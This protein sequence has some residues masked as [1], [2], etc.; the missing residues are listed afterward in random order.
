MGTGIS[1]IRRLIS[2][3]GLKA[4]E[5]EFG[6]FFMI[7]FPRPVVISSMAE[8]R[9]LKSSEKN[10]EEAREEVREKNLRLIRENPEITASELAEKSGLASKGIEWNI[11]KMK[12][13]RLIKRIGP[14]KGGHWE[15]LKQKK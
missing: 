9:G 12:K 2:E 1:K 13:D 5:F 7:T 6:T 3:A 10:R 15:V 11:A 14:D 4:P 8:E